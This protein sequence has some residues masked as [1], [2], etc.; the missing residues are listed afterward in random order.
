[1]DL[2]QYYTDFEKRGFLSPEMQMR[3]LKRNLGI[4]DVEKGE[5]NESN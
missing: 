4:S 1:M 3:D 2:M 5:K